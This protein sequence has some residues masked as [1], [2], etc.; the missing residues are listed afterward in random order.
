MINTADTYYKDQQLMDSKIVSTYGLE[1]KDL[2]KVSQDPNVKEAEG[3]YTVDVLE[4]KENMVLRL[5]SYD[6]NHSSPINKPL[7]VE[8]RLPQKSGEIALDNRVTE[9]NKY[10]IGDTITLDTDKDTLKETSYKIVGLVKSPMYIDQVSRGNTTIGKG[11][12]DLFGLVPKEDFSLEV[13]TEIYVTYHNTEKLV[14]YSEAYD[15][16]LEKNQKQLETLL[17][18]RTKERFDQLKQEG[19]TKLAEGKDKLATGEEAL[20][21]GEIQLNLAKEQLQTQRVSLSMAESAGQVV[22]NE[23]KEALLQ[24]EKELAEKEKELKENQKSLDKS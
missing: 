13:F 15:K 14:S 19:T 24:G 21:Q 3:S 2:D 16:Q 9:L 8:G 6:T 5:M 23:A 11:S 10:K 7:L 17:E 1:Q 12:I 22:P 4:K 18:P 20:K